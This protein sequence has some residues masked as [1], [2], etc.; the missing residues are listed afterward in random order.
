[1]YWARRAVILA[2]A[3]L[4]CLTWVRWHFLITLHIVI[5]DDDD[6]DYDPDSGYVER[7]KH[8]KKRSTT[9]NND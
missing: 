3:Q 5:R 9:V 1:M 7:G 6:N 4:S 2:I 8:D